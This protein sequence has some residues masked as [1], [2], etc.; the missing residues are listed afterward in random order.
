MKEREAVL[1]AEAIAQL[2]TRDGQYPCGRWGRAV[3]GG[4]T[5][6]VLPEF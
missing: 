5:S 4:K 2:F 3:A 1:E 6:L